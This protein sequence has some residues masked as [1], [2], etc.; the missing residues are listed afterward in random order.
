MKT[1]SPFTNR[2]SESLTTPGDLFSRLD[3]LLCGLSR[4]I[5]IHLDEPSFYEMC[6]VNK[7][8]YKIL[9]NVHYRIT[10]KYTDLYEKQYFRLA[11]VR[12]KTL[13]QDEPVA[14][15]EYLILK[16]T[17]GKMKLDGLSQHIRFNCFL[18]LPNQMKSQDHAKFILISEDGIETSISLSDKCKVAFQNV[19]EKK[20]PEKY[21][22]IDFAKECV[23]HYKP[24]ELNELGDWILHQGFNE[25]NLASGDL[26]ALFKDKD[27]Q[28]FAV[29]MTDGIYLSKFGMGDLYFTS[30]EMMQITYGANKV[31]KAEP[32]PPICTIQ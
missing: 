5:F 22:C 7:H 28:H 12:H 19:R 32:Q 27:F 20:R 25:Q 18:N 14:Y 17:Y 15:S 2:H 9:T 13:H 1:I 4:K 29:Y 3:Q 6:L 26:V 11:K 24:S 30:L 16:G 8:T 21:N 23:G 10:S 31:Y